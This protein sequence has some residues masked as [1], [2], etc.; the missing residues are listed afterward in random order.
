VEYQV[1]TGIGYP[2]GLTIGSDGALWFTE[3]AVTNRIGRITVAGA[4]AEYTLGPQARPAGTGTENTPT[5]TPY[6]GWL[7]AGSDGAIWFTEAIGS[8]VR[9]SVP[10]AAS[11]DRHRL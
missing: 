10:T 8:I 7:A 2:L 9:F 4:I 5:A 11:K 6:P 3:G 1:P